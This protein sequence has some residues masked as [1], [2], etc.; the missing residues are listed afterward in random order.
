MIRDYLRAQRRANSRTLYV[1]SRQGRT[2]RAMWH[3]GA[4]SSDVR[5]LAAQ[6]LSDM[7]LKVTDSLE[8]DLRRMA[9]LNPRCA[10]LAAAMSGA[11]A[12]NLAL[13]ATGLD[14]AP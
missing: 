5:G 14:D 1:L 7:S 4:R 13:L 10:R 11:F 8:P 3:V 12:A 9:S 2:A 6:C